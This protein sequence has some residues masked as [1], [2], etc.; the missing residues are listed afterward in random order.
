[1]RDPILGPKVLHHLLGLY[2]VLKSTHFW[3][4]REKLRRL[5]KRGKDKGE[6]TQRRKVYRKVKSKVQKDLQKV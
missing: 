1:M 4:D 5:R 3:K 2:K 6:R